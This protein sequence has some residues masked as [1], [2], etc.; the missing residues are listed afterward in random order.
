MLALSVKDKVI[1]VPLF[2]NLLFSMKE[3]CRFLLSETIEEIIR[4]KQLLSKK[5]EDSFHIFAQ[6]Q[7]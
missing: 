6:T 7:S 1:Y 4:I 3:T 5:N 2:Q